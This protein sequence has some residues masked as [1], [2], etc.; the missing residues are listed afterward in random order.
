LLVARTPHA[1][2]KPRTKL[3]EW[4]L[5]RHATQ[6]DMVRDTGIP[7]STYQRIEAGEYDRLP[8]Q[9]LYNCALVLDV[10][11][12]DLIDERFKRWTTYHPSAKKPPRTPS[13]R[14]SR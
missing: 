13:W 5:E 2:G 8:Y 1:Q 6:A 12:E 3:A 11:V 14:A 4:R 9:Q 10:P 7:I